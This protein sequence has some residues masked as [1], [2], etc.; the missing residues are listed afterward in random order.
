MAKK[1]TADISMIQQIAQAIAEADNG[2]KCG[3]GGRYLQLARAALKPL[4]NPSDAIIDAAHEAVWS[5]GFWAI[6]SRRDFRKAVR[7]MISAAVKDGASGQ[8]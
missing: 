6:N 7:A 2:N 3:D 5:D 8:Q 4:A 1:S